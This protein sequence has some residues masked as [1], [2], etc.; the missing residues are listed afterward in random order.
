MN[1]EKYVRFHGALIQVSILAEAGVFV[2]I[3]QKI[4]KTDELAQKD[5]VPA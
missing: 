1:L 4:T 5:I 2:D 3:L